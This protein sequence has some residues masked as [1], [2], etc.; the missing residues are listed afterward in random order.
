[1]F[2]AI[3]TVLGG[4]A[5]PLAFIQLGAQ[6]KDR[7]RA[8]VSK[9][10]VWPGTANSP[11]DSSRQPWLIPVFIRNS[12][13]LPVTVR[14]ADLEL[15]TRGRYVSSI[16]LSHRL[17]V[18]PGQ[19]RQESYEYWED[20][21]DK[22]PAPQD[23]RIARMTLTDAAGLTWEVRPGWGGIP[24]RIQP[25]RARLLLWATRHWPLNRWLR[26]AWED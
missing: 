2:T 26:K 20:P 12:S 10:G 1:M 15:T 23:L 8:Q 7:L 14:A 24:Q 6:R 11:E 25:L 22:Q 19:T 9:V 21:T 17:T 5:L 4:L 3:G 16:P 13:E 18:I